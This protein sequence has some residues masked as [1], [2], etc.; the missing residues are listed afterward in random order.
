MRQRFFQPVIS[1]L[2]AALLMTG[3]GGK[4]SVK[5]LSITLDSIVIDTTATLEK[6]DVCK[7]HLKL[8]LFKGPHA[9][10]LND[11]LLRMGLLQPDYM[12]L[13]YEPINPRT[14]LPAFVRR[15]VEEQ[16]AVFKRIRSR[17]PTRSRCAT[18]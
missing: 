4:G 9:A 12:A 3:C 7:V 11:S 13:S 18:S 14:A 1:L 17:K 2:F 16:A 8:H 15:L 10:A 6:G 5:P